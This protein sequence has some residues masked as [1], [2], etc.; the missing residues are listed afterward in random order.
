[1][2]A[3]KYDSRIDLWELYIESW[4]VKMRIFEYEEKCGNAA[5]L[6]W[7]IYGLFW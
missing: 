1:M 4:M 3:G 6:A 5:R 2:S 7:L